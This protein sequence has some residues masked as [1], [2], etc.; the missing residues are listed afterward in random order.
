MHCP[1]CKTEN[2]AGRAVCVKCQTA[3]SVEPTAPPA[4]PARRRPRRRG[5]DQEVNTPFSPYAEGY[6]RDVQ[7]A[8]RLCLIGLI[9]FLGLILGPLSA[10]LASRVR[11]KAKNDPGF[12][13]DGPARAA[14]VLGVLTGVTNWVGLGLMVIGLRS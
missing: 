8:Y 6:N 3:L 9:P 12:T 4:S 14:V 11:R 13:A 2:D 5:I 1:A 7:C 10:F